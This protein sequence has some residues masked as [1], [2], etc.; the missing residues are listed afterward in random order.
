MFFRGSPQKPI[1]QISQNCCRIW[2]QLHQI[3]ANIEPAENYFIHVMTR[4]PVLLA[5][6]QQR[7][8]GLKNPLL[9]SQK[10]VP[11]RPPSIHHGTVEKQGGWKESDR[12]GMIKQMWT[13]STTIVGCFLSKSSI[14][15]QSKT[16]YKFA[17]GI[18]ATDGED[19]CG[20][21]CTVHRP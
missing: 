20:V 9:Q 13:M 18:T 12:E 17:A 15:Q 7:V 10:G 6:D 8:H 2:N 14:T 16:H 4:P 19:S 21:C 5:G 1:I 11:E 3:Y